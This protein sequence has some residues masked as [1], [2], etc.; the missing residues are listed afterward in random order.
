MV[1][2]PQRIHGGSFDGKPFFVAFH[3]GG[4]TIDIR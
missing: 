3:E 4:K 2:L 1:F